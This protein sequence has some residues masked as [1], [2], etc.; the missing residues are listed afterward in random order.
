VPELQNLKIG[1][2]F[3]HLPAA[4]D[5]FTLISFDPEHFL[6][7]AWKTPVVAPEHSLIERKQ[8]LRIE[9]RAGIQAVLAGKLSMR[10]TG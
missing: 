9:Q 5:G 7:L 3:P 6:V 10:Y 8:L 1:M 2:V 4:T